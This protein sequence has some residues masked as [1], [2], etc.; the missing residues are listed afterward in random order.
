[1]SPVYDKLGEIGSFLTKFVKE[2]QALTIHAIETSKTPKVF[3][4]MVTLYGKYLL[5]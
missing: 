1:M 5:K 2:E 3:G 4:N